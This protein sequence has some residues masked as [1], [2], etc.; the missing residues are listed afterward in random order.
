MSEAPRATYMSQAP[1]AP[2]PHISQPIHLQ[3][4]KRVQETHCVVRQLY[5]MSKVLLVLYLP[6]ITHVRTRR[7]S[8][9]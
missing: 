7:A 8:P 2:A 1:R 4:Q 9:C 6:V 3:L 5:L